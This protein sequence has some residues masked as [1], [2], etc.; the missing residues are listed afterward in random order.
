[1]FQRGKKVKGRKK[2]VIRKKYCR[3]CVEK[4]DE[5]DYR[6]IKTLS[7]FITE[8]GKI[9]STKVSG[10]CAGHQKKLAVAIKRARICALLPFAA[11]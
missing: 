8:R 7:G 6:D 2:K 3:L 4:M 1:M 11:Q 10:N 9:L 5:V